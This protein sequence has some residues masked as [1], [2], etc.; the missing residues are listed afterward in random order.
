M[1]TFQDFLAIIDQFN[2][3][4]VLYIITSKDVSG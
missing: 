4:I 1:M 2:K 3:Q